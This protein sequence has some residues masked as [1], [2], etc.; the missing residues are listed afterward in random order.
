VSIGQDFRATMNAPIG[1]NEVWKYARIVLFIFFL[2]G[3]WAQ[4]N[5]KLDAHGVELKAAAARGERI[6]RYLSSKDPNYW[7]TSKKM[8]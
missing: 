6:E 1:L 3:A 7:E 4:I 2:G 8:E 5:A